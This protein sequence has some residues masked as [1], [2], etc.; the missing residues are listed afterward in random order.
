MKKLIY[1][2]FFLLILTEAG[3][4]YSLN[5]FSF[6]LESGYAPNMLGLKDQF[7]ALQL[8]D[9]RIAQKAVEAK[10]FYGD[11]VSI[12]DFSTSGGELIS[13]PFGATMRYIYK[14]LFFK[15]SFLYHVVLPN[16][17]TYVL[18]TQ[19]GIDPILGAKGTTHNFY[20]DYFLNQDSNTANDVPEARGL[21]PTDGRDFYY[22]SVTTARIIEIPFTF[23]FILI[24]KEYYRFYLGVGT[25]YFDATSMRTIT[26]HERTSNGSLVDLTGPNSSP[27][28]DEFTGRALG[29]NFL[30]GSEFQV[31]R[32]I[33][34][35][36][37]MAY[38]I[39]AAVPLEDRVRTGSTTTQ[40][41]F[42]MDQATDVQGL[43]GSGS[44]IPGS[45]NKP[46]LPRLSGLNFEHYR[47]SIG[48]SYMLFENQPEV[49]K[50]STEGDRIPVK[51]EA[52]SP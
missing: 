38:T 17:K 39:G 12:R 35:Y 4:V 11:R 25:S 48:I 2:F 37:E 27:D 3:K 42:H 5:T 36:M 47:L 32:R 52:L 44:E 1:I 40:S 30:L 51:D 9:T 18:N 33:G 21:V 31:T 13:L 8:A 24:G 41:L 16:E 28:I 45:V 6:S 10:D 26:V 15:L 7:E 29:F 14:R 50:I 34:L 20:Q 49:P 46:G 43:D 23:G 19:S 22:R